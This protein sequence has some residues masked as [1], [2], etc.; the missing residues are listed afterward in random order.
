MYKKQERNSFKILNR[1][2][3]IIS[4]IIFSITFCKEIIFIQLYDNL[5][6]ATPFPKTINPRYYIVPPSDPICPFDMLFIFNKHNYMQREQLDHWGEQSF[7][8]LFLITMNYAQKYDFFFP[9]FI[10]VVVNKSKAYSFLIIG[11]M[12]LQKILLSVIM[13]RFHFFTAKQGT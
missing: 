4:F 11:M 9:F 2:N 5:N 10:K 7:K 3:V 12:H 6:L 1:N 13:L 8:K